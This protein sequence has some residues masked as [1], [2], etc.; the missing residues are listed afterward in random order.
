LEAKIDYQPSF[1]VVN[2]LSAL[3]GELEM[4]KMLVS[5]MISGIEISQF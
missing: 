1:K 5:L 4:E 2:D 3:Y